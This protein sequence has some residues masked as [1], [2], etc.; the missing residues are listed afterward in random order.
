MCFVGLARSG[1][2]DGGLRYSIE[3]DN[4]ID[5]A[6]GGSRGDDVMVFIYAIKECDGIVLL[7][8]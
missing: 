2:R 4:L 5:G 8:T 6:Y 3:K 1:G 7:Y